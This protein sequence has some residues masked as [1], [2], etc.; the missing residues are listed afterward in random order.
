MFWKPL[1]IHL[2][3]YLILERIE[4]DNKLKPIL[5]KNS[6]ERFKIAINQKYISYLKNQKED[7]TG[8]LFIYKDKSAKMTISTDKTSICGYKIIDKFFS[9]HPEIKEVHTLW[10]DGPNLV[11]FNESLKENDLNQSLFKTFTGQNLR[12]NGFNKAKIENKY[13]KTENKFNY[14]KATFNK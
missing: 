6:P 14:I 8:L 13:I 5:D 9:E 7:F 11:Q 3:D 12:R 2:D 10:N 1:K 4:E